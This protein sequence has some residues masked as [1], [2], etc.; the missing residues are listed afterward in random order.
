MSLPLAPPIK[1]EKGGLDTVIAAAVAA[2]AAAAGETSCIY[3]TLSDSRGGN[4]FGMG[5]GSTSISTTMRVPSRRGRDRLQSGL[6]SQSDRDSCNL[7]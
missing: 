3:G 5:R 6:G 1:Q 2:V 7:S 4:R